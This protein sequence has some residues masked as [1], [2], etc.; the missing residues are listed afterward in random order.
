MLR[1]QSAVS[2]KFLTLGLRGVTLL[3]MFLGVATIAFA[4]SDDTEGSTRTT[5]E[6]IEWQSA[7]AVSGMAA[8]KGN[9][10]R[11]GAR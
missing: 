7:P 11:G 4:G 2:F 6:E 10:M 1:M 9:F 8:V 3:T 5:V